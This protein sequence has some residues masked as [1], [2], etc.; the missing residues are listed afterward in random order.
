[1]KRFMSIIL[2]LLIIV[3]TIPYCAGAN[4][5]YETASVNVYYDGRKVVKEIIID[6][7][8]KMVPLSWLTYFGLLDM[9]ENENEYVFF[10]SEQKDEKDFARRIFISKD[11]SKKFD[12]G[13]YYE[14]KTCFEKISKYYSFLSTT[15]DHLKN[16]VDESQTKNEMIKGLVSSLGGDTNNVTKKGNYHIMCSGSFSKSLTYNNELYFPMEEVLPLIN[17]KIAISND[18]AICIAPNHY[19]LFR[20]LYGRDIS[21]KVFDIDEALPGINKPI[22]NVISYACSSIF[23][24]FQRLDFITHSG[25]IQDYKDIFTDFL[26]DDEIYLS[27]VGDTDERK[28]AEFISS[29]AG[30][31]NTV[32]KTVNTFNVS[33]KDSSGEEVRIFDVFADTLYSS[34]DK[35]YYFLKDFNTATKVVDKTS[36][37]YDYLYTYIAHVEDHRKMLSSVYNY[38]G[39]TSTNDYGRVAANVISDA[40]SDSFTTA[41]VTT[42]AN[43]VYDKVVD[44]TIGEIPKALFSNL[45][46]A[47]KASTSI[48][49][50]IPSTKSALEMMDEN[51]K[52]NLYHDISKNS[53]N[54]F[55]RRIYSDKLTTDTLENARLSLLMTMLGSKNAYGADIFGKTYE[56]DIKYINEII[57]LIY[58]AADGTEY[59]GSDY[60]E[61]EKSY[62]GSIISKVRVLDNSNDS[63]QSTD[64]IILSEYL[65]KSRG[66]LVSE[67]GEKYT[68]V[69]LQGTGI[70]D[71]IVFDSLPNVVFELFSESD[72]VIVIYNS[73]PDVQIINGLRFNMTI[74]EL[75]RLENTNFS[76]EEY[77]LGIDGTHNYAL[78]YNSGQRV[79]YT[80]NSDNY[81]Y[82][83]ADLSA[84]Q[85]IKN[86][87]K[88]NINDYKNQSY[89]NQPCG[90]SI[91]LPDGWY[92][93]FEEDDDGYGKY[94]MTVFESTNNIG[95][96]GFNIYAINLGSEKDDKQRG[97]YFAA[98][99]CGYLGDNSHYAFY[100]SLFGMSAQTPDVQT[101]ELSEKVRAILE[102]FKIE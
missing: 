70:N 20:L 81:S 91:E 7:E 64:T 45:S 36:Q 76:V 53:Y 35:E 48:M 43:E 98:P 24:K 41:A 87:E 44:K 95:N 66:E 22:V 62:L 39:Y 33:D 37:V 56:K 99:D 58:L 29:S 74:S 79:T 21:S 84:I 88:S 93:A 19:S 8:T 42:V 89:T 51:V 14:P 59:E 4:K 85:M 82:S 12:I 26:K 94:G 57:K 67:F 75:N 102:S 10:Y 68:S 65:D 52:L 63:P 101:P 11:N 9:T 38:E 50:F 47:V 96:E 27:V 25:E 86:N 49:K 55:T 71:C 30:E 31:F 15:Y 92:V 69:E 18:G 16:V 100:W 5:E 83:P 80:W 46:S 61:K 72:H 34:Y 1:M 40:Y 90:W 2:T 77:D 13:Y 73:N 60:Y 23:G 97:V 54:A 3:I 32:L 78:Q 6:G 17:A 28:I